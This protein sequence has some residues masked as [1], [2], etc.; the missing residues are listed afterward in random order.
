MGDEQEIACTTNDDEDEENEEEQTNNQTNHRG[1]SRSRS[2]RR[3][4]DQ[5]WCTWQ[6][7]FEKA[8]ENETADELLL[9]QSVEHNRIWVSLTN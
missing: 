5:E 3:Q 6:C 4:S 9:K 2:C 1:R 8:D 7:E